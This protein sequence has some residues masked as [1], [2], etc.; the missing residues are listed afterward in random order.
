MKAQVVFLGTG[1][2]AG[3]PMIGCTCAVCC[4]TFLHNKRLRPSILIQLGAKNF[5]IDATPDF[6]QQALNF[7]INHL[8]GILLTHPHNDHIAGLNE[9]VPYFLKSKKSIPLLLS[10][11]TSAEVKSH[12]HY[13]LSMK[14][15][16]LHLLEKNDGVAF[17]E[18]LK[19][20]YFS[21]F[22]K[23]MQVNGF[24]FKNFAYVTDI[25]EYDHTL[26]E[27]L[28][29]V[30]VLVIS[31]SLFPKSQAHI[32]FSEAQKIAEKA[33]IRQVFFTHISHDI[34]HEKENKKLPEG[35]DIAYDG[36]KLEVEVETA[37]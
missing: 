35:V 15:F 32:H 3:I 19:V 13:L 29:G 2:S 1:G 17:F 16:Q 20:R 7:H 18:G 9:C 24:R 22:Q 8:D 30:D 31:A 33:G 26:F 4:S 36:L 10:E 14:L 21:Y 28:E 37:R 23:G 34:E 6:R 25:K 11:E 27:H 5:L 12:Y